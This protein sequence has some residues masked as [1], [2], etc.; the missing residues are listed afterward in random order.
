MPNADELDCNDQ[1]QFSWLAH[2]SPLIMVKLQFTNMIALLPEAESG[3]FSIYW[4][5]FCNT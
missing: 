2:P 5:Y 4:T 3:M 1:A